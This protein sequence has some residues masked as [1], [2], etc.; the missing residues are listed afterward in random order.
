MQFGFHCSWLVPVLGAQIKQPSW[1][2][3]NGVQM[4]SS[5]SLLLGNPW[6]EGQVVRP[7]L[8][9]VCDKCNGFRGKFRRRLVGGVLAHEHKRVL[10]LSGPV[11]TSNCGTTKSGSSGDQ[12][13]GSSHRAKF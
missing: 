1:D 10:V 9:G 11:L 7:W 12:S 6:A 2:H 3:G 8:I 5:T 4:A 13:K